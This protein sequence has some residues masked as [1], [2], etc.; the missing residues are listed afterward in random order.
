[1]LRL[2][3]PAVDWLVALI[4]LLLPFCA[5]SEFGATLGFSTDYIY[6][7]YTKSD[8]DPVAQLNMDYEHSIG[9]FLGTWISMVDFNDDDFKDPS[10]VEFTPYLG[11]TFK[12]AEDWRLDARWTRNIYDGRIFNNPSDFNEYYLNLHFSDLV[13][14]SFSFADD[15]F[16]QKEPA[17]NYEFKARYPITDSLQISSGLGF[18][19][20]FEA[21]DYDYL[22]W[23]AGFTW[24]YKVL[25][26]DFRYVD[27]TD[28]RE[29]SGIPSAWLFE[30]EPL[31]PTFLFS[32]SV[33]F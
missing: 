28:L 11:W 16:R 19:Q 3:R 27:S 22:Y 24:F 6:R 7:G 21:L 20:A 13:T 10:N 2:R 29:R 23:D 26:F 15:A 9:L 33:G 25:A 5:H 12:L 14:A 17:F 8:G 1:M 30:P 4:F 31:D 18:Y 32:I